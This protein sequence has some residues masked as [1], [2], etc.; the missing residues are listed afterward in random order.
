MFLPRFTNFAFLCD[1]VF[2][3]NYL[4]LRIQ[5]VCISSEHIKFNQYKQ[6]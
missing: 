6:N 2:C 5:S 3:E 1:E 4:L